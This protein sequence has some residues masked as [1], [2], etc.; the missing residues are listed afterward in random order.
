[1]TCTLDLY[2]DYLVSSTG[3]TTATGLSRLLAGAL[4]H[5][6]IT[7]WLSSTTL[8]SPA[9]WRQAKPLIRQAEAPRKP[10]DFAVLIVDDSIL[11]KA[12]TD[13]NELICTHYDHSQQR[14]LKGLHFV[15]LLYQASA[16][17][18]AL[19]KQGRFSSYK[20]HEDLP[21]HSTISRT[22][23]LYPG[24]FFQKGGFTR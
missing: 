5:D 3:P 11:Q 17:K 6:H 12:H 4:S 21:Q 13:V 24:F 20:V 19:K 16:L 14:F 7:R 9:L 23:Q 10:D 22:R 8:G 15:A 18:A 1:M 2:T